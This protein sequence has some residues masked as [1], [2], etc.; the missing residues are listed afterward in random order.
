MGGLGGQSP[1]HTE[2]LLTDPSVTE[3]STG[4]AKRGRLPP[5][6]VGPLRGRHGERGLRDGV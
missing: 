2:A 5:N 1:G 4:E 6:R 3:Q